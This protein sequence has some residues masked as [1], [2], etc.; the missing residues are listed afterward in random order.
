MEGGADAQV[1]LRNG[2]PFMSIKSV[3]DCLFVHDDF[4]FN[5]PTATKDLNRVAMAFIDAL[6]AL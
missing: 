6:E 5:F 2:V 1:C 4:F 3:S